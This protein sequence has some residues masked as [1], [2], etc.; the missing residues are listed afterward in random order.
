MK[1]VPNLWFVLEEI[2]NI[3]RV[4]L[5]LHKDYI[6]SF[7]IGQQVKILPE[8]GGWNVPIEAIGKVGTI[9]RLISTKEY[10]ILMP[11]NSTGWEATWFV[12]WH[13]IELWRPKG[14]QL[15]FTFMEEDTDD[16]V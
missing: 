8:A 13:H 10:D 7:K 1:P 12:A 2:G 3:Y 11:P 5:R 6:M 14:E 16:E 15:L 4:K 9:Y